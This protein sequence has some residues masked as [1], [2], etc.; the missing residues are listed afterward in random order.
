MNKEKAKKEVSL[1]ISVLRKALHEMTDCT[2]E[3]A[4]LIVM[5]EATGAFVANLFREAVG[6]AIKASKREKLKALYLEEVKAAIEG[7]LI[8]H[9]QERK[10]LKEMLGGEEAQ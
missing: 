7:R 1:A 10:R 2:S 4:T 3:P 8:P 9:M 5:L 6:N